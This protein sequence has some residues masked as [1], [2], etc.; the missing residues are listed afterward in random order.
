M[1][2]VYGRTGRIENRRHIYCIKGTTCSDTTIGVLIGN[3]SYRGRGGGG[4]VKLQNMDL[5]LNVSD[6][7]IA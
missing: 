2:W 4:G 1:F 5:L 6:V 3:L 7:K